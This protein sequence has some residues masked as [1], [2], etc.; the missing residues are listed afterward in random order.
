MSEAAAY[1]KSSAAL[2]GV[3]EKYSLPLMFLAATYARMPEQRD[4]A[5][6]ILRR[7]EASNEYAS[8][9]LLSMVY[10]ALGDRDK[11]LEYLEKAYEQRDTFL[12]YVYTGYEFDDLRHDPRFQDLLRR[13]NL[14]A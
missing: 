9:V 4:E 11:A 13:M 3:D 1:F 2:P 14:P 5:W 10:L 6:R 7:V 12:R 8:P